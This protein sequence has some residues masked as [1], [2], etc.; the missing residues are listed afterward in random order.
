LRWRILLCIFPTLA[1]V[2]RNS[3]TLYSC[4]AR[5][6][7]FSAPQCGEIASRTSANS[8]TSCLGAII[9]RR[10]KYLLRGVQKAKLGDH[11]VLVPVLSEAAAVGDTVA[12]AAGGGWALSAFSCHTPCA[13]SAATTS[14]GM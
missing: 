8:P 2:P 11:W 13:F 5:C 1:K 6:R 3:L 9:R 4:A 7:Q 14:A 10:K 12:G